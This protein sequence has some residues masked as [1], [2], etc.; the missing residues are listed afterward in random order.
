VIAIANQG[1]TIVACDD[2]KLFSL[3]LAAAKADLLP[4]NE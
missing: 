4:E 1:E 3:P 2:T